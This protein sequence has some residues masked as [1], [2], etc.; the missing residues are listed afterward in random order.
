MMMGCL[1]WRCR[2]WKM[3]WCFWFGWWSWRWMIVSLW[4]WSGFLFCR[5]SRCKRC[6]ISVG[7]GVIW[8]CVSLLLMWCDNVWVG[9]CEFDFVIYEMIKYND[10]FLIIRRRY[11]SVFEILYMREARV[12]KFKYFFYYLC[13]L[14]ICLILLLCEGVIIFIL[15]LCWMY[16][17]VFW[18][19]WCFR[20]FFSFV[21]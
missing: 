15:V 3:W 6:I 10:N 2:W 21:R 20:L 9:E 13:C 5:S 12:I 19:F 18:M 4:G 7:R 17:C 16:L 8:N 1:W 14:F 11:S